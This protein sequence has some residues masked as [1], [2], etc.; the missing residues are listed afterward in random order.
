[1]R[2]RPYHAKSKSPVRAENGK[3]NWSRSAA[4]KYRC[5]EANGSS[6]LCSLPS[7][8]AVMWHKVGERTKAV[9]VSD[10]ADADL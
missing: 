7:D 10:P 1:M 5:R 9:E 2:E 3:V 4:T 6:A 8:A